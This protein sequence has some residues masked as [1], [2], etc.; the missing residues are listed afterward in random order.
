MKIY[1]KNPENFR[2][3]HVSYFVTIYDNE[4]ICQKRKYPAKS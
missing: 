2:D 4:F 3:F 1:E